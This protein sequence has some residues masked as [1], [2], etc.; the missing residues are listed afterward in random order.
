ILKIPKPIFVFEEFGDNALNFDVY[1][2]VRARSPMERRI[3]QSEV[4]FRID[5][6]FREH[7][8]IIAF[9]QRDVH[10]DSVAPLEVRVIGE[11]RSATSPAE[12]D[13]P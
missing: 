9:P 8:L 5:D 13:K 4:R 1:F 6:L 10:I 12:P 3:V 2:W 11:N 7:D